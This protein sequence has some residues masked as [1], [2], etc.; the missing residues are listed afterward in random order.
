MIFLAELYGL[1]LWTTNIGNAQLEAYTKEKVKMI[2]GPEFGQDL[3]VHTLMISR[4]LY[5]PRLSGKLWRQRVVEFSE[6]EGFKPYKAEPGICLRPT[7]DSNA[8]K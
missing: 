6:N 1:E 3:E 5:G 4:V 7:S 8:Y 2:A